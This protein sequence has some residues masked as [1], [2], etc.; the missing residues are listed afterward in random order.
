MVIQIDPPTRQITRNQH[1][2]ATKKIDTPLAL[3]PYLSET[4]NLETLALLGKIIAEN[5]IDQKKFTAINQRAWKSIT[6]LSIATLKPNT[7]L[8]KF[9]TEADKNKILTSC[10][11]NIDGNHLIL[12]HWSQ[13]SLTKAFDFSNHNLPFEFFFRKKNAKLISSKIGKLVGIDRLQNGFR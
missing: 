4:L 5:E 1:Q 2:Q 11:W 7:F 13:C 12:K 9:S 8:S 6:G 10:P 3:Q